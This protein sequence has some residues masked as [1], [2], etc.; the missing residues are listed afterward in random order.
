MLSPAVEVM[1]KLTC[2]HGLPPLPYVAEKSI[3][4]AWQLLIVVGADM[5][6]AGTIGSRG[7]LTITAADL[8]IGLKLEQCS[9]NGHGDLRLPTKELRSSSSEAD[10]D[11]TLPTANSTALVMSITLAEVHLHEASPTPKK[12]SRSEH[13][14]E[15]DKP[16]LLVGVENVTEIEEPEFE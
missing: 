13:R 12:L 10:K 16:A 8:S 14:K 15:S 6:T 2:D 5:K 1:L 3:A 4:N 9:V 7:D 11:I